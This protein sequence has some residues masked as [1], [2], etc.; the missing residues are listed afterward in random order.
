MC[1]KQGALPGL[2]NRKGSQLLWELSMQA[3]CIQCLP[4]DLDWALPWKNNGRL[5]TFVQNWTFLSKR[6][7]ISP[8]LSYFLTDGFSPD[9]LKALNERE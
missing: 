6:K 5:S 8:N 4:L 7:G 1:K 3:D 9:S 2:I